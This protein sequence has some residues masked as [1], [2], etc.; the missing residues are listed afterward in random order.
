MRLLLVARNEAG[1]RQV[2]RALPHGDSLPLEV[3]TATDLGSALHHLAEDAVDLILLD[4][5][6]PSDQV[7]PALE[8]LKVRAPAVPVLVFTD[9]PGE[10]DARTPLQRGAEDC[11]LRTDLR[12]EVLR[13][14]MW[15]AIERSGLRR[16]A[17]AADTASTR[18][19][20]WGG[21]LPP[22]S[23]GP[24][25]AV[26]HLAAL[27][28]MASVGHLTGG[29]AHEV[30]NLL[31]ALSNQLQVLQ[32]RDDLAPDLVATIE[33]MEGWVRRAAGSIAALLEYALRP[34]GTRSR[35]DLQAVTSRMLLLLRGSSRFRHLDLR[36]DF[37]PALPPIGLDEAA[38]EHLVFE[39][40]ANAAEAIATKGTLWIRARPLPGRTVTLPLAGIEVCF[41]DDGPGIS[42]EHLPRVFEPFFTTRDAGEH[43]GLGLTLVRSIV[44]AHR[45]DIAIE[46]NQPT[47]TRVSILLPAPDDPAA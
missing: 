16:A 14:A 12:P 34:Q 17:K 3:V 46:A 33:I 27:A 25:P 2:R 40:A 29:V 30:N 11:L 31:C 15:S 1:V 18:A 5:D 8:A 41:E 36:P 19:T 4:L 20:G 13:H 44:Q 24:L 42:A 26:A 7:H 10:G 6:L 39:L 47:G 37:S 32:L 35:V 22:G 9:R 38:W 43:L 21:D 23:V 28:R 45:G